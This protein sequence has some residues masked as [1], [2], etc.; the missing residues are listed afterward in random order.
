MRIT[1]RALNRAYLSL[2]SDSNG[3]MA[4]FVNESRLPRVDAQ[5]PLIEAVFDLSW[6]SRKGRGRLARS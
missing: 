5:A 3:P 1:A 4:T 2:H 6:M